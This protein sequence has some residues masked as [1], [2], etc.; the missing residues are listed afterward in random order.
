MPILRLLLDHNVPVSV[1]DVFK[2]RCHDVKLVRD[3][4]PTDSPDVLVAAAS[5]IEGAIL[6]SCDRDFDII[7]PRIPRGMRSRFRRL[8][9]IS[10]QC[11][12]PKAAQRVRAAMTLIEAEHEIAENS[13][14]PRLFI[15]IQDHGIK[16]H[17]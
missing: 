13:K 3:I 10:L 2:A 11:S 15:V 14:D 12:E 8:S 17:R 5:E 9:R 6:V 16:T 4:L 7:A 1:A